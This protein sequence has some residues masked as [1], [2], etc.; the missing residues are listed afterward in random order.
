MALG[1]DHIH[2]TYY[3]YLVIDAAVHVLLYN[4]VS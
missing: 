4:L 1:S 2:I 3:I